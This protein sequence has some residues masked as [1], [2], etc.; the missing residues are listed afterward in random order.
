MGLITLLLTILAVALVVR[1]WQIKKI[2]LYYQPTST[3]YADFIKLT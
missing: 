1:R 2:K 3:M